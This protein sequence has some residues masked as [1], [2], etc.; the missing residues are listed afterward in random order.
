MDTLDSRDHKACVLAAP[1]QCGKTDAII[2]WLSHTIKCAPADFIL[3]QTSQSV[4]RDFSRRRIDRLHRY[5]PEIGKNLMSRGD[6][7]NVFDKH[8][9]SGM[10]LTLSWPTIN[11]MS[12]RP[13]G[14][15]ALTDYDRMPQDIDGE[16][17]P[18]DLAAKRT[19]TFGSFAMTFA[20][21]SPGFETTNP[22]WLQPAGCP[23]E[24][25]P[26]QGILALYNRGDRRRWYVPCPHCD[27]YFEPSFKLMDW[28]GETDPMTAAQKVAMICPH[29]GCVIKPAHK[30]DINKRGRWLREGQSI[31][32]HGQ[33]TGEG[34]VSNIASFWLK[35][36]AATFLS[37][38]DLVIK[39]LQAEEEFFKTGSQEAL[40]STVNTDQG[41]P[42]IPRGL[43]SAR[44]PEDL[45]D[46][47]EVI[48]EKHV[49]ENTRCLLASIDVQGNRWEVQVHGVLPGHSLG[50]YDIVVIDRFHIQKSNRLDDDGERL[51]VKPGTYLE[52]WDLITEQVI[53]KTYPL[54]D[55]SGRQM[56]IKLVGCDSG[57]KKGVT[58]MA[59]AYWRVLKK[60]GLHGRFLLL[61]GEGSPT[62]PRINLTH[63]DSARKDRM[64]S[65]R[66]EIPVLLANTNK[67]KDQLDQM[68]DRKEPGGGMIRFPEWL[69]DNFF[70]ELTVEQKDGKGRWV[71]PKSLRNESWDLLVYVIAMAAHLKIEQID[72]AKPPT[73]VAD[74][75]TNTLVSAANTGE[76]RFEVQQKPKADLKKL[77]ADLA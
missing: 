31:D 49:P 64:A 25:P 74:W 39:Y 73:W 43:G 24:A 65:A 75:E 53:H 60:Q 21:S 9:R 18:F 72:W 12:G 6:S 14:K 40:K 42:Y 77:A 45:K 16:G 11:E 68:L 8:Y 23:H 63:P 2:N 33:I 10:M 28:G 62:A 76:R 17:A 4:A 55:G 34:R 15:V 71:N 69:P 32:R 36:P 7:D 1:A 35:G 13:V 54:A 66:G 70:V 29:N 51:W 41:E 37:W 46:R 67:L 47:A 59:Y 52:D 3:Y 26:C 19:T 20:E 57:G 38:E 22:K 30:A 5:S 27:E 58:S 44:L 48:P 61:K 56:Q 50:T